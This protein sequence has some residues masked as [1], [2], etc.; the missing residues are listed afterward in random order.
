MMK[1]DCDILYLLPFSADPLNLAF[2]SFKQ[3]MEEL[4]ATVCFI[5]FEREQSNR[6]EG[7][8]DFIDLSRN[9][10]E[11][12]NLTQEIQRLEN[13]Y[14]FS[15]RHILYAHRAQRNKIKNPDV[16]SDYD[17]T[18]YI[19]NFLS[20][21]KLVID[22]D[23][24]L[25]LRNQGTMAEFYFADRVAEYHDIPQAT[26]VFEFFDRIVFF[27]RLYN[28][29]A[30]LHKVELDPNISTRDTEDFISNQTDPQSS[31]EKDTYARFEMEENRT[32]SRNSSRIKKLLQ[33]PT[34]GTSFVTRKV[35]NRIE[36]VS[37][38]IESQTMRNIPLLSKLLKSSLYTKNLEANY[39]LLPLH[40]PLESTQIFRSHPFIE[41]NHLIRFISRNL[42]Y[43]T[44]LYVREHP[45]NRRLYSYTELKRYSRIPHVRIVDPR[46]NIHEVIRDSR[47]VIAMN[48][49]TGYE[50]LMNA[51]PVVCLSP[52]PYASFSESVHVSNQHNLDTAISTAVYSDVEM[53]K[54]TEFIYDMLRHSID[55]PMGNPLYR[56]SLS[57][58][59][60]GQEYAKAV[61]KL[62]S[63][64]N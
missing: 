35:S 28:D 56:R 32:N 60:V 63:S 64:I 6:V 5:S 30:D 50:S 19:Q 36:S 11:N 58:Q 57:T 31:I 39:I 3:E 44:K 38:R 51:K 2:K 42:P 1:P 37:N 17:S 15:L 41:T 12:T 10:R 43:G 23:P 7:I 53:S 8:L 33:D 22:I 25:I 48:N 55:I 34:V 45:N 18:H 59:K 4:G 62:V 26:Q 21:E 27:D 52:S 13:K 49:T 9:Q 46:I 54:V 29:A 14:N 40:K 47:A 24:K 20:L 16:S 61:D